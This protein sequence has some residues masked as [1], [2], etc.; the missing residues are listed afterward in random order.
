[1]APPGWVQP[2]TSVAQQ[3]SSEDGEV[4]G[5]HSLHHCTQ[6]RCLASHL[7]KEGEV[8][9]GGEGEKRV[10]AVGAAV[11]VGEVEVVVAVHRTD[12]RASLSLGSV[13]PCGTD[14]RPPFHLQ[15][16]PRRLGTPSVC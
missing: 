10:G 15:F 5:L 3:C 11:M 13:L 9:A 2:S 7:W 4:A 14:Q 12:P 6:L 8:A 16:V 1:M